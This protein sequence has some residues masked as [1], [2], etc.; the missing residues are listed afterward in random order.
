LRELPGWIDGYLG[1]QPAT[2]GY[3]NAARIFAVV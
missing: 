3:T 1:L 2:P